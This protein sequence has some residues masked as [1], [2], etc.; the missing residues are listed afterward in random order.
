MPDSNDQWP[1]RRCHEAL[2]AARVKAAGAEA[3]TETTLG[4]AATAP[5]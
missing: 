3:A 5:D 1:T 2:E 4:T